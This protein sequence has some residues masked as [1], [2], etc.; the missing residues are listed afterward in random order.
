MSTLEW[1]CASPQGSTVNSAICLVTQLVSHYSLLLPSLKLIHTSP[2][3][4]FPICHCPCSPL[5]AWG[6]G[7]AKQGAHED[8]QMAGARYWQRL[9]LRCNDPAIPWDCKERSRK[10]SALPQHPPNVFLCFLVSYEESNPKDPAAVT[11]SKEE[12]TGVSASK[13]LEK[14]EK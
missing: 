5:A 11:E 8:T 14:K 10:D 9:G 12:S 6:T 2:V 13:R 1:H 7:K 4:A 3:A